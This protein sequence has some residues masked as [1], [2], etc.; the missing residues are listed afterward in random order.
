MTTVT[1]EGNAMKFIIKS[2]EN[3]GGYHYGPFDDLLDIEQL[4]V[5]GKIDEGATII[6]VRPMPES[7]KS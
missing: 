2:P 1:T 4:I 5:E 7:I 3:H 6:Q